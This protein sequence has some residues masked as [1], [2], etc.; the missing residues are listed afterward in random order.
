MD[1]KNFFAEETSTIRCAKMAAPCQDHALLS[2][3]NSSLPTTEKAKFSML[4]RMQDQ[5]LKS[6]EHRKNEILNNEAIAEIYQI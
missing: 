4:F 1:N 2:Q 5:N 6:L 3:R